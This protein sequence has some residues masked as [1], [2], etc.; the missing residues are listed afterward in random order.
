M[1][2]LTIT[3]GIGTGTY[4]PDAKSSGSK[5]STKPYADERRRLMRLIDPVQVELA[6]EM[7]RMQKEEQRIAGYNQRVADT[8]RL[9]LDI[10]KLDPEFARRFGLLEGGES[11][12]G[13][14]WSAGENSQIGAP[15]DS[16]ASDPTDPDGG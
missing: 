9:E 3:E 4:D 1:D 12:G 14:E 13:R 5:I 10:S 16:A 6:E 2:D 15:A 8:P 11:D 7:Q